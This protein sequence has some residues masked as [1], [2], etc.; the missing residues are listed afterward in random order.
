MTEPNSFATPTEVRRFSTRWLQRAGMMTMSPAWQ[1][2]QTKK[3]H[4]ARRAYS[5]AF[6]R[7]RHEREGTKEPVSGEQV[8]KLRQ[9]AGTQEL[10]VGPPC[11]R[12]LHALVR[13]VL[14]AQVGVVLPEELY[15]GLHG[16]E[17][18]R[19]RQPGLAVRAR[20]AS[21]HRRPAGA[22]TRVRACTTPSSMQKFTSPRDSPPLSHR[23]LPL[24]CAGSPPAA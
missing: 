15:R 14:G 8:R 2:H 6:F 23:P 4:Q 21:S 1:P 7:V 17:A 24:L 5:G 22:N 12:L 3:R 20:G 10:S 11:T 13:V 16:E 19:R 18:P 9:V